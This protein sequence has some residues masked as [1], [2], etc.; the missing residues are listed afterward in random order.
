[1]GPNS[2][3]VLLEKVLGITT[4]TSSGFACD[5]NTGQVAYPTGCVVV[6]LNPRKNKQRHIFNTSRKTV[7]ALSFSPDGKYIVTGE[8]GHHPAVRVWEVEDKTQVSELHGH[9][10]GVACVAFSPS[11]KY[12]VSVGY[13]HDMVVNVWDWKKGTLIASNKV[14][15]K[16]MAISFSEDSYFVTVG[17]RH[18]KFWFLDVAREIKI[19]ET[20]PLVGRSGLLGEL[21]NNIFCDVACG[22]GRMAR[23]TFCISF[24]GLLCQF[25]EKR[26]LEKWIDLKVSLANCICISEEFIFCGGAM[27]PCESSKPTTCITSQTCPSLTLWMSMSPEKK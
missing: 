16:V 1:K 26:V 15:S 17:H 11:M 3:M 10:H 5:P 14:S 4:Q 8:S 6:I 9:K 24:S 12:L 20:V 27:A 19:K 7:S 23:S 18:V 2:R 22:R 21:H 25:N 13:P